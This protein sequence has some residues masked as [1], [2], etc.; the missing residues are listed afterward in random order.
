ML[1]SARYRFLF[2]H[3][4]KVAGTSVTRAL[5]P[6]ARDPLL[7]RILRRSTTPRLPDHATVL[8]ARR[9]LPSELF[10]TWFKFAFVRNPW[11]W[12]VSLFHY[13]SQNR[14]H[15]QH[16][17]VK[18]MTFADYIGWRVTKDKHL[19]KEFVTDENGAILVDFIGRYERLADDF[20][21]VC[22]RIGIPLRLPHANPS[23]HADYRS[24]YDARTRA[25][26]E[27]HFCEDIEL[28]GYTF[29]A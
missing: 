29:D 12:Q 27:E 18:S 9:A 13:M 1:L 22:R 14:D 24:Y 5:R 26:I 28:F 21:A 20:A 11:D 19:Q 23:R 7:D 3:I 2:V 6:F 10:D 25:L 8:E 16:G 17:I 15:P 4:Y